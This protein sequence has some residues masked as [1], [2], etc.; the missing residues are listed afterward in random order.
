MKTQRKV[1]YVGG[2]R[3]RVTKKNMMKDIWCNEVMK[4]LLMLLLSKHWY[5]WIGNIVA[6]SSTTHAGILEHDIIYIAVRPT[7][8]SR[9]LNAFDMIALTTLLCLDIATWTR[10]TQGIHNRNRRGVMISSVG[11]YNSISTF[12][13]IPIMK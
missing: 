10:T 1:M 5:S 4:C 9:V 2:T 12:N 11:A 7:S 6:Q 13:I 8:N 3:H